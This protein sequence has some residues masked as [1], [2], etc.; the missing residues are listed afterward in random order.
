MTP[1][2][3]P[4][5]Q[6]A[7]PLRTLYPHPTCWPLNSPTPNRRHAVMAGEQG[8][9][10]PEDVEGSKDLEGLRKHPTVVAG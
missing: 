4:A 5:L 9:A 7:R 1:T 8:L 2:P 10:E 6:T 3:G